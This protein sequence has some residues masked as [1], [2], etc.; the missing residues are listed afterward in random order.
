MSGE[1]PAVL[2]IAQMEK[3]DQITTSSGTSSYTLLCN[4]GAAVFSAI[5]SDLSRDDRILVACGSGN[6]GGDGLVL[7]SLLLADYYNVTV[8]LCGPENALSKDAKKALEELPKQAVIRMQDVDLKAYSVVVDALLGAGMDRPVDGEWAKWINDIN[9]SEAKVIAIDIP[10]GI[11]GNTGQTQGAAI[12]AD[13]TVTFFLKKP[14]HLLLPGRQYVGDLSV[15][16]IGIEDEVLHELRPSVFENTPVLWQASLPIPDANTHKYSRGH[17]V[18]LAGG[19]ATTGAARLAARAALRTGAGLVTVACRAASTAVAA[20]HLTTE[21][22]RVIDT[23]AALQQMLVDDKR[24]KSIL[25]GPGLGI[26]QATRAMVQV[27]LQHASSVVLDADALTVYE[28]DPDVLLSMVQQSRARVVITPHQGEFQLLFGG[29]SE[30]NS[31]E[32]KTEKTVLAAK[33]AGCVVVYKGADTVIASGGGDAVINGGAPAWLATA[34][35]GDVLAGTVAGW[36]AQGMDA[37]DSACAACWLHSQ[38]ASLI[39]PGLIASDLENSYPEVLA[40]L[41]DKT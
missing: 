18:V 34:G 23:P 38:A 10:T 20:A 15:G 31:L 27:A 3:A 8:A 16:Q 26:H 7:A 14:G 35:T 22:L 32:A 6:N 21:M 9:S 24:I 40:T 12:Q 39:G 2:S 28:S 17:A 41:Y 5:E 19:I 36:L 33:K 25:L 29:D 37:F 1:Y 4:A 30:I 11:N 13:K